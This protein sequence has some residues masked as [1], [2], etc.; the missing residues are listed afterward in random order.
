MVSFS[1]RNL[2][3]KGELGAPCPSFD[4]T[5]G[6][7][8]RAKS[9][10]LIDLLPRK[11]AKGRGFHLLVPS[12]QRQARDGAR[13]M[14]IRQLPDLGSRQPT[15]PAKFMRG[16]LLHALCWRRQ[17]EWTKATGRGAPAPGDTMMVIE[18]GKRS[19]VERSGV[20]GIIEE[21]DEQDARIHPDA[22]FAL[23]LSLFSSPWRSSYIL[24]ASPCNKGVK[25]RGDTRRHRPW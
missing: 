17:L 18:G 9:M 19:R 24:V 15:Y 7:S 16:P 11:P 5:H 13:S 12:H 10:T 25:C 8:S 6:A 22:E 1:F 23:Y 4:L 14:A 20:G 3:T 2:W 21:E